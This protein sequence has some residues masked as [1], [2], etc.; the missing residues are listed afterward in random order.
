M[1]KLLTYALKNGVLTHVLDVPNGK[2]CGCLCPKC[3]EPLVAKANI[4]TEKYKK[5]PHFA[6]SSGSDCPGAY[7]SALHLLAKKVLRETK[8]IQ[9]PDFHFDYDIGNKDSLFNSLNIMDFEWVL[10][11]QK[12]KTG[13]EYIVADV[14]CRKGERK[15]FVEFAHTHFVDSDKKRKIK[16]GNFSL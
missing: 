3:L 10:E 8:Q 1:E 13:E 12:V 14:E 11:E 16:N 4:K 6:H 15:L 5:E 2:E 7:E 9:L